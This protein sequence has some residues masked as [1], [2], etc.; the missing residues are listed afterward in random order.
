MGRY[1]FD[2]ILAW[3]HADALHRER[4][5]QRAIRKYTGSDEAIP[6]YRRLP[7]DFRNPPGWH[8]P[9]PRKRSPI[10]T[11]YRR[12]PQTAARDRLA[13]SLRTRLGYTY[14]Q[15]ADQLGYPHRQSAHKAVVRAQ[16]DRIKGQSHGDKA[17]LAR[18]YAGDRRERHFTVPPV[19][20]KKI[21]PRAKRAGERGCGCHVSRGMPVAY[22]GKRQWCLGCA[23]ER[24]GLTW[25]EI[26]RDPTLAANLRLNA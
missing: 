4:Q 18:A 10:H 3:K 14:Q 23:L 16:Q 1:V 2:Q 8:L 17:P 22:V 6:E 5:V 7:K 12:L 24:A 11:Q 13:F 25:E 21:I 19:D 15:I 20:V 9:K 26:V